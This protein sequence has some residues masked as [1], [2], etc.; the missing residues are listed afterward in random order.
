MIALTYQ[1]TRSCKINIWVSSVIIAYKCCAHVLVKIESTLC[2]QSKYSLRMSP[3]GLLRTA[4]L[5]I[6]TINMF[7]N[8]EKVNGTQGIQ[9]VF[10]IRADS[11]VLSDCLNMIR[12][13]V[14]KGHQYHLTSLVTLRICFYALGAIIIIWWH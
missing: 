1:A 4:V 9:D 5:L 14:V 13:T 6:R 7:G 12:N 2:Y 10:M 8:L 11:I 3:S